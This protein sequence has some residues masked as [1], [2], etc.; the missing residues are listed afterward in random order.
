MHTSPRELA[1]KAYIYLTCGPELLVMH[2]PE[3]PED[4]GFQVAG[5]TVDPGESFLQAALREFEEE[6]GLRL[7]CALDLLDEETYLKQEV[8]NPGWQR[9]VF[10]HARL[11]EKP[12]ETWD[13]YEMHPSDGSDPIL[14]RYQWLDL[15][16]T[17][18]LDP[19]LY[20]ADFDR[21]LAA[22]RKRLGLV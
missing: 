4:E 14:L 1:F 15:R 8:R 10:Y 11:R 9:R 20:Y 7:S 3:V 16:E 12:A 19:S 22:L 6:T 5:G 21:P 2:E 17:A 13:H 18:N